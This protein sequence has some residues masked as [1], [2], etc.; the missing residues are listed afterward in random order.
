M[1]ETESLPALSG[2]CRH[3]DHGGCARVGASYCTCP[4]HTGAT[5]PGPAPATKATRRP[6]TVRPVLDPSDLDRVAGERRQPPARTVGFRGPQVCALVGITYRQL[7]YWARTNMLRPSI[8]DANGSGTQRRYSYRDL[9]ELQVVKRLIDAGISLQGA[10]RAIDVLR[11]AGEDVGTANL[12]IN[13]ADSVLARSGD[14]II[15]LLK[16]GQGVLHIVALPGIVSE[17]DAAI[18]TLGERVA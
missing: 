12:V 9:L 4:C 18:V 17:L 16:S 3:D 10:R 13:G 7:D 14:E 1:A 15:D 5:P 2:W 11:Q 8:T 6:R